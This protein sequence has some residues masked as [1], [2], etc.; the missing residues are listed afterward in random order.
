MLDSDSFSSHAGFL[1]WETAGSADPAAHVVVEMNAAA[2]SRF[3]GVE[4]S[5]TTAAGSWL[6]L[7]ENADRERIV[8]AAVSA[9]RGGVQQPLF[10]RPAGGGA[11][12]FLSCERSGSRLRFIA[13]AEQAQWKPALQPRAAFRSLMTAVLDLPDL[14]ILVRS[15]DGTILDWSSG[16]ERLYGY[17]PEDVI[18][19]PA[20]LLVDEHALAEVNERLSRGESIVALETVARR[21]DGRIIDVSATVTPVAQE[22]R[23]VGA[24]SLAYDISERKRN[25][26]ALRESE[27][28]F[29]SLIENASDMITVL[30]D[31]GMILY[32]SP[33]VER[34]LGWRVEE[35]IGRSVFELVPEEQRPVAVG[36]LD[37]LRNGGGSEW[38]GIPV[39]HADGSLRELEVI[40]RRMTTAD[41][42]RF[43]VNSRDIT[44]RKMLERRLERSE[45]VASLGQLAAAVAH[46]FNNVLMGIQPFAEIIGR[47]SADDEVQNAAGY[48]A[49]SVQRGRRI[50]SEILQ[51]TR[52]S[53]MIREPVDV[54]EWVVSFAAEVRAMLDPSI[55]LDVQLVE[56]GLV[57][58]VDRDQLHQ[59]FSNLVANARDAMR[60]A[61]I[62]RLSAAVCSPVFA[63]R[64]V[65]GNAERFVH[66]VVEDSGEGMSAET[67]RHI[68]EPLYTTKRAAGTGLGLA[69]VHQ[70]V[71]RHGGEI[72][73]ES[74]RGSGS[75]FHIFLPRSERPAGAKAAMESREQGRVEAVRVLLVEDEEIVASGISALLEL[76]SI[77]MEWVARGGDA[78]E[79][80][81]RVKP[82]AVILDIGLPDIDGVTLY[83]EIAARWPRLPTIFST[84]HG[85]ETQLE[86]LISRPNVAFLLKPYDAGQLFAALDDVLRAAASSGRQ[87]AKRISSL[88]R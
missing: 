56:S 81:E 55:R 42:T 7:F 17:A 39:L 85:D 59:I 67:M 61:G 57:I 10:V 74:E 72:S 13:L 68:F 26:R 43:I 53:E 35:L 41:E 36:A 82:D 21:K 48:I 47:K 58:D 66:F 3:A 76:E 28:H 83:G 11:R 79:A 14:A 69:I 8:G 51:Y 1:V 30:D 73:V 77:E 40:A 70:L 19:M 22:G 60:G 5:A 50:T 45:R 78:F 37:R 24:V 18:G 31:E 64:L 54:T 33:S 87:T 9:M 86:N 20:T 38:L 29:R 34:V 65:I 6:N 49:R 46:E 75:C 80:I 52:P 44:E 63:H 2:R 32:E 4:A 62:L 84:G 27:R 88:P 71:K 16:A 25:E 15:L 23:V 12:L